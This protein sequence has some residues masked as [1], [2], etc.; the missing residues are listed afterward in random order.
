MSRSTDVLVVGGGVIGFAVAYELARRDVSVLLV[1]KDLPGRAT[2][3]SAGGLWPVGEAVGLGCGVIYQATRAAAGKGGEAEEHEAHAG[4]LPA[5]FRDLLVASNALFPALSAELLERAG[6][7]VEYRTGGGLLF[8]A[9]DEREQAYVERV[10]RS[11]PESCR[12]E[13]LTPEEAWRVEPML[14]RDVAGAAL[15]ADEHQVNPMLLAEAYKRAAIRCGATFRHDTR[16]TALR[17]QGDRI[18]GAEIEGES[19]SARI[20][21]NAAGAWSGMLAATAGLA[22]PVFPI[23]GQIVLTQAMPRTL[24][25]CLST[26]GCY[27]AQKDHGEILIGSTTERAG[28]DVSVTTAGVAGLCRGAV[29]AVPSLRRAGVKRMWAGLRPGTE[30]ELPILGPIRGV[31]GYV[32]ASGGF[33]TGIVAAP[34]TARLVAQCV[35]GEE[36]ELPIAPFLAERFAPPAS[37]LAGS[38]A[39]PRG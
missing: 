9:Y 18:V 12:V 19:L 32:N 7:D 38:R 6:I 24:N 2:S 37:S 15:L 27:M 39:E 4:I 26:S 1:D 22:V 11:L 3:A 8:A 16:V 20:V 31:E 14:T 29:R 33:R 21:V 28:F 35:L 23:R 17:R 36:L 5:S 30:D 10:M 34:M 13:R 25:A